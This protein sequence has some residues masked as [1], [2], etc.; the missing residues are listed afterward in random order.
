VGS[1]G[2]VTLRRGDW[3][4]DGLLPLGGVTALLAVM[5]DAVA[6]SSSSSASSQIVP[7]LLALL[8]ELL[9][10]H[11]FHREAF[12]QAYGFH[13]V[14]AL[15]KQWQHPLDKISVDACLR[16]LAACGGAEFGAQLFW[17]GVQGLLLDWDLWGRAPFDVQVRTQL[18][19]HSI[20]PLSNAINFF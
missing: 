19:T 10:R 13:V 12:L 2:S 3:G 18:I 1:V 17:A 9:A 5:T 7:E 4:W 20:S 14:A 8:A 16:L 6:T 15:L 11:P